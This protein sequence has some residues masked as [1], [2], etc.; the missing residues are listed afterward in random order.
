[1]KVFISS[2]EVRG[3]YLGQYSKTK[4]NWETVILLDN[5]IIS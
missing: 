2:T 1:L 3:I 5:I 4:P